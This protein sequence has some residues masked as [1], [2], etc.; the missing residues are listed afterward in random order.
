MGVDCKS[1]GYTYV[2]SNPTRP[3]YLK[4]MLCAISL[5]SP[6]LGPSL[7]GY[8]SLLGTNEISQRSGF[9]TLDFLSSFVSQ[10]SEISKNKKLYLLVLRI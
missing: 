5:T 7:D 2:G 9:E 6:I 8:A 10:T 4:K 3:I 1:A